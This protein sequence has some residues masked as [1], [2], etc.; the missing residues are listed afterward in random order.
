MAETIGEMT[1]N[2]TFLH[3]HQ[4]QQDCDKPVKLYRLRHEKS[5]PII[6]R[7]MDNYR[8]CLM[9]LTPEVAATLL[10][11]TRNETFQIIQSVNLLQLRLLPRGPRLDFRR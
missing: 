6:K 4:N 10:K 8:R 2:M 9:L 5:S 1:M 3:L 11:K 7:T